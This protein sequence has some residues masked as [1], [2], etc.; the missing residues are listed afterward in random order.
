[1][2]RSILNLILLEEDGTPF[3]FIYKINLLE[4]MA[5][6]KPNPIKRQFLIY[7]SNWLPNIII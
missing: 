2:E 3:T 5:P 4:K 7:S 6:Q 1:M